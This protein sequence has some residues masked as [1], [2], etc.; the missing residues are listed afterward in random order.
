[1]GEA[2]SLDLWFEVQGFLSAEAELLDD[3]RLHEWIEL[4][5]EDVSYRIPIRVTRERAGGR[6]FSKIGFHMNEDHGMLKTRVD[7]LDTEY[8]FA[9]DPPSRTRRMIS[10]VRATELGNDEVGARSNLLLYRSRH[11]ES[12]NQLL[13]GERHDV[14]RRG[15]GGW[16]IAERVV[17]LD[18]TVLPTHNLAIFL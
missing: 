14:L 13:A 3:G 2:V 5:T 1:M 8:A 11:G 9:E 4:L 18:H 17:Y 10:N 16:R 6:G 12:G 7:R 15:E